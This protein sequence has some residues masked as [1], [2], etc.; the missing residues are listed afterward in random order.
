MKHKNLINLVHFSDSSEDNLCGD[1]NKITLYHDY[2][3]LDLEKELSR[4]KENNVKILK[5][6][7]S[8]ILLKLT[9]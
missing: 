1:F 6:I 3:M 4:R 2:Y 8:V 7:K 9:P 5:N